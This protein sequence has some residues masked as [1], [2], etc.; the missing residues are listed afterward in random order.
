M[1]YYDLLKQLLNFFVIKKLTRKIPT[2]QKTREEKLKNSKTPSRYAKLFRE[3]VLS[4]N[5]KL[6][7]KKEAFL[8]FN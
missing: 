3:L 7:T 8:F 5:T 4:E 6:R 1:Y 2:L